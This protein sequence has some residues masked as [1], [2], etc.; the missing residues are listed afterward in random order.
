M[1]RLSRLQILIAYWGFG[2]YWGGLLL[3]VCSCCVLL[4]LFARSLA[5]L[6]LRRWRHGAFQGTMP[7]MSQWF[8]SVQ[9]A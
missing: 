3:H 4:F 2:L 9:H 7:L 8:L 6:F 1:E 5:F